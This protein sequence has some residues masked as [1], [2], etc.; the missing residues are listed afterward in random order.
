MSPT[1]HVV[2][3]TQH[4][5]ITAALAADIDA[6]IDK[7]AGWQK[8][9]INPIRKWQPSITKEEYAEPPGEATAMISY[10]ATHSVEDTRAMESILA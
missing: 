3:R 9:G 4:A 8:V 7:P 1:F 6:S 10:T 5:P 2:S